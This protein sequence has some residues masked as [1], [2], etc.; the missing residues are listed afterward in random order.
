MLLFSI[1]EEIM[2]LFTTEDISISLN[3]KR[4]KTFLIRCIW[5]RKHA[6]ERKKRV[7]YD[8]LKSAPN[9]MPTIVNNW[10]CISRWEQMVK[11]KTGSHSQSRTQFSKC[12][13][14]KWYYIIRKLY[15]MHSRNA[16]V[17]T[18]ES[19]TQFNWFI[20]NWNYLWLLFISRLNKKGLLNV[21]LGHIRHFCVSFLEI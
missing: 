16:N 2:A 7:E 1:V 13:N 15:Y 19:D 6:N 14:T 11:R 4:S 3:E 5:V 21:T 20:F 10:I 18:K 8:C 12:C 17:L 9:R